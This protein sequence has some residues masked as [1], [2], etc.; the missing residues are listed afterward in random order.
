MVLERRVDGADGGPLRS[1]LPPSLPNP[2]AAMDAE[3]YARAQVEKVVR[4]RPYL[5]ALAAV[6]ALLSLNISCLLFMNLSL[7]PFY[8]KNAYFVADTKESLRN[9]TDYWFFCK[10]F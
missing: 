9:F 7:S 1:T 6:P 4:R 3:T 5:P 10:I 8:V 2:A